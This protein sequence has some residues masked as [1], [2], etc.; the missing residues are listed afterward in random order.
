VLVEHPLGAGALP[1]YKEWNPIPGVTEGRPMGAGRST[2]E[3][4]TG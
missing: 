2:A 3:G 4:Y 1:I